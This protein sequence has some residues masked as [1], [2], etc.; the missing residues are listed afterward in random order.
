MKGSICS[1]LMVALAMVTPGHSPAAALPQFVAIISGGGTADMDDGE[2]PSLFGMN[3]QLLSGGAARGFFECVDQ[4]GDTFPGNFFGQVSSWSVN[5][6]GQY[7]FSGI[8]RNVGFPPFFFPLIKDLPFTVTIQSFGGPG[9]G[10]W[11]L[12][13]PDFGGTVCWETIVS[14]Q[15]EIR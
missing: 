9:V 6:D 11:T 12:D 5:G 10:H 14:G 8:G 15:V 1:G 3:A 13:L 4:H 7:T 2:G